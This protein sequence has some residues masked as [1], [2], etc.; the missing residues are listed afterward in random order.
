MMLEFHMI[1]S[2]LGINGELVKI[3]AD[4]E[5]RHEFGGQMRWV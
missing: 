2:K 5:I 3:S 4:S 1:L